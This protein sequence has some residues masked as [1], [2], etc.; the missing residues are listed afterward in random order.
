VNLGQPAPPN[1]DVHRARLRRVTVAALVP[2]AVLGAADQ[3]L[4]TVRFSSSERGREKRF[5]VYEEAPG[6]RS[7]PRYLVQPLLF[8]HGQH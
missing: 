4:T 7:G 2:C 5:R 1:L 8:A 3:G 6:V